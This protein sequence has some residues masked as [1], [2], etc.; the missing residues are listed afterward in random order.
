MPPNKLERLLVFLQSVVNCKS[1][2]PRKDLEKG[3]GPLLWAA[4]A[5]PVLRPWLASIYKSLVS[6]SPRLLSMSRSD[7]T[8]TLRNQLDLTCKM[9][10][11]PLAPGDRIAKVGNRHISS[12]AECWQYANFDHGDRAWIGVSSK[13]CRNIVLRADAK[14]SA[15]R[16]ISMF[17]AHTYMH[18]L[19]S[20]P[21]CR[22]HAAADAWADSKS[23]GIG[24]WLSAVEPSCASEVYWF[25]I[26][27]DHSDLPEWWPAP[28]HLQAAISSFELL[29]QVGLIACKRLLGGRAPS[30][31]QIRVLSDSTPAEGAG[32]RLFFPQTSGWL[33]LCSIWPHGQCMRTCRWSSNTLV[34][35]IMCGRTTCQGIPSRIWGL[36][37]PRD[38]TPNGSNCGLWGRV[39]LFCHKVASGTHI[40]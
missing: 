16:W 30:S 28:E 39:P 5:T 26:Q 12:T 34:G 38:S 27:F 20:P 37:S 8:R 22:I 33:R 1:S 29:A 7:A 40:W 17:K 4:W 2:F 10:C 18:S 35:F 25:S 3:L 15:M 36:M 11:G 31:L 21:S 14:R 13:L 9:A 23:A 24:G 32:H 6:Y 19:W